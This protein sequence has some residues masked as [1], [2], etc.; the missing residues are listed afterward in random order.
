MNVRA[1]A[2][3]AR[4]R[5]DAVIAALTKGATSQTAPY[6]ER[7]AP[8]DAALDP[9][10]AA[11]Q[12]D[13]SD[14]AR[15]RQLLAFALRP[16]SNCVDVGAHRGAVLAEMVRVAPAGRHL[17]FEPIPQL[18]N[19]LRL[20]FPT[21]EVRQAA[22]S[23]HSGQAQFAHVRGHAE[24]WSGLRF[25]P[26]PTGE[27]ADVEN[28]EVRL[29]MLDDVLDPDCDPAV[30]KIDV[31]GA[32][33]QVFEG[34]LTTLRR[35]RPIVIFEHGSGSAEIYGTTPAD[36]HALL[37]DEVGYR[38]FDLDGNGPYTLDDL[39]RTFYAGDRVNF[40]AHA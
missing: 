10:T 19:V 26:L 16:D 18:C 29:E 4:R 28:I 39:E 32:E 36:I 35:H 21:V 5:A 1:H 23:N 24:G 12:R 40:V 3:A 22:L 14:F 17:A 34:A 9:L 31:E 8:G 20:N 25:R 13:Q 7:V 30:I 33:Q 2:S 6:P 11:M 15:M 38:I 37:R 27:E